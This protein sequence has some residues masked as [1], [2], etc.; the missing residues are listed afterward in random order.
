MNSDA[1]GFTKRSLAKVTCEGPA[2]SPLAQAAASPATWL[3]LW[4]ASGPGEGTGTLNGKS[5]QSNT[6]AVRPSANRGALLEEQLGQK[7]W[8]DNQKEKERERGGREGG[9]EGQRKKNLKRNE[10]RKRR[11]KSEKGRKDKREKTLSCEKN[12]GK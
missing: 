7:E 4:T 1:V 3:Q 9:K 5:A 11:K 12:K 6:F 2:A 10:Q 8:G